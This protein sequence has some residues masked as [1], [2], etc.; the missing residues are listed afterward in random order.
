MAIATSRIA[1]VVAAL[2]LLAGCSDADDPTLTAPTTE[3]PNTSSTSESSPS[4]STPGP[5]EL[6]P[7][8]TTLRA[9]GVLIQG[10]GESRVLRFGTT[11]ANIGI[12]PI[13]AVPDAATP[14]PPGQRS[15]DQ[16][17]LLDG[18]GDGVYDAELDTETVS[19]DGVCAL[20]HPT[21][22]HWHIDGSARYSLIDLAGDEVVGTR[23][24]SFCLRDSQRLQSA[25]GV[26]GS[27]KESFLSC[28]RDQP[29]GISPG[30][31]DLYDREL[32][33][34][35]LALPQGMPDDRYCLR[36]IADPFDRFR[37]T[38]ERNNAS[39]TALR[40]TGSVVRVGGGWC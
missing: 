17:V 22:E 31:G 16:V 38:E 29:Q 14:C 2:V 30:W 13:V 37:E 8:L 6:R 34:Q 5:V 7:D 24:V 20:F 39:L 9:T 21:H 36:M 32:D 26:Q 19:H 1:P 28:A 33:G 25:R 35:A 15:F 3:S 11:L 18:N 4:A 10:S 27:D 12:G 40:I 23:K